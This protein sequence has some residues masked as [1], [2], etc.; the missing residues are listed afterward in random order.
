MKL[1][2]INHLKYLFDGM[3]EDEQIEWRFIA[4]DKPI[5]R[6][7]GNQVNLDDM[8]QRGYNVFVGVFSRKEKKVCSSRALW[9][10]IDYKDRQKGL[11]PIDSSVILELQTS[12][13][14][15]SFLVHS[16]HGVHAYWLLDERIYDH[17]LA[18]SVLKR[19][20][21]HFD[22]DKC[23]DVARILRVA[24]TYNLKDTSSPIPTR[25]ETPYGDE[26]RFYQLEEITSVIVD[27]PAIPEKIEY[28][29]ES[30]DTSW[31]NDRSEADFAVVKELIKLG[32]TLDEI[33]DIYKSKPI[34]AKYAEKEEHGYGRNYI[35][36]T[37][38]AAK[39]QFCGRF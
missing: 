16:G 5:I 28:I 22:A 6:I 14:P 24:G 30:G 20:V 36:Y 33:E 4:K 8:Q 13:I 31:F 10:D 1:D 11:I 26:V 38:R 35:E 25:L 15:P 34:G 23:H 21:A 18:K 7:F 2:T 9:V 12:T 29:I 17:D 32:Y 19:L 37:Y 27:I 3:P 39:K